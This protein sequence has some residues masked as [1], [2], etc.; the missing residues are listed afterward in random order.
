MSVFLLSVSLNQLT[1]ITFLPGK[2]I[3]NKNKKGEILV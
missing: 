1:S 3:K 2:D